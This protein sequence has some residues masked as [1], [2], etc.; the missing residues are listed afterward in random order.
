MILHVGFGL[1]YLRKK[2]FN[3]YIEM[4]KE[5]KWDDEARHIKNN[6]EYADHLMW[7]WVD[8]SNTLLLD[9]A[10]NIWIELWWVK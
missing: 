8:Y 10:E 4:I 5:I 3:D 1:D 7:N 2:H 6:Y 9:F